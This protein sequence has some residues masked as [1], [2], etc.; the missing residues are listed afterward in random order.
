[1]PIQKCALSLINKQIVSSHL[2]PEAMYRYCT[3]P[4]GLPI[5]TSSCLLI[6]SIA[7]W[8]IIF[9]VRIAKMI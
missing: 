7:S 9:C 6:E 2:M 4:G 8:R 3:P 1:M 5:S